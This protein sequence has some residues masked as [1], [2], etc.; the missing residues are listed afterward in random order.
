MTVQT[1]VESQIVRTERGLT[2]AGTRITIYDIMEFHKLGWPRKLIRD[3]FELSDA[4][5]DA[6]LCYI[7]DHRSE[8]EVEYEQVLRRAE[9]IR[10]YWEARNRERFAQIAAMPP[11]PGT[12]ALWARL[13]TLKATRESDQ[14]T[15]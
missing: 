3:N 4:Q 1:V 15:S 2:I 11:K 6:V 12:E 10:Q 7:Q 5:I 9:E 8:V 13:N 14:C